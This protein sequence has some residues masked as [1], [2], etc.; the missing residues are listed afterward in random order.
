MTMLQRALGALNR[1]GGPQPSGASERKSFER[2]EALLRLFGGAP[3]NSGATVTLQSAV[4]VGAVLASVRVLSQGLASVPVKLYRAT[5][6]GGREVVSDHPVARALRR[7]N[8]WQTTFAFVELL[9]AQL[10]LCGNHFTLPVRGGGGEL[11][12]LLPLAPEWITVERGDWEPRYTLRIPGGEPRTLGPGGLLHVR[13]LGW[14]GLTGWDPVRLAR[15]TLGLSLSAEET[16]ASLFKNSARPSGALINDGELGP[17]EFEQLRQEINEVYVGAHNSG[18]PMLFSNGLKWQRMSMTPEDT[19]FIE[20]RRYLVEEVARFFGVDPVMIFMSGETQAYASVEAKFGQHVIQTLLPLAVRVEQELDRALLSERDRDGGLFVKFVLQG[21]MRGS[22]KD[23]AE[24]YS[25][26]LGSGGHRP[27][28]TQNE[29]RAL[30]EFNPVAGGDT[31]E[32]VTA[33]SAPGV[34]G[35]AGASA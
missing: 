21:L 2:S 32:P 19:Q 14:D 33:P 34:S 4:Q 10:A 3:A 35:T 26:A 20:Q 22:H 17:D 7:P 18:R 1:R 30:E 28:L 16:A 6:D 29:V 12:E 25:A 15:E 5:P 24:F 27:F 9:M 31:L 13:G 11:V 8:S 23:R